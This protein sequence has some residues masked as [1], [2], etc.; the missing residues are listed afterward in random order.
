MIV[1]KILIHVF[2]RTLKMILL[3]QCI[4]VH[5]HHA[6]SQIAESPS[7]YQQK[8]RHTL[9]TLRSGLACKLQ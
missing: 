1:A 3:S 5:T 9:S 6:L 8:S 2:I 7:P 4:G